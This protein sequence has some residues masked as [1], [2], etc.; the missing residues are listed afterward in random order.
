MS[1]AQPPAATAPLSE[2]VNLTF[3]SSSRRSVLLR[4][5]QFTERDATLEAT[6]LQPSLLYPAS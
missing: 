1:S 6:R 2:S 4:P 5:A 3:V